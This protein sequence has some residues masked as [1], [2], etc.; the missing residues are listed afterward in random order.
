MPVIRGCGYLDNNYFSYDQVCQ[1][2][3]D[4]HDFFGLVGSGKLYSD[5]A[6]KHLTKEEMK[7]RGTFEIANSFRRYVMYYALLYYFNKYNN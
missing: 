3:K 1:T 5:Q 2:G 7:T 6:G 4:A